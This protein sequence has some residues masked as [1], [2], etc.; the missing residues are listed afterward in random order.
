MEQK[1]HAL[2]R[3]AE[4]LTPEAVTSAMVACLMAVQL[5]NYVF[6]LIGPT[7]AFNVSKSLQAPGSKGMHATALAYTLD[8]PTALDRF[9]ATLPQLAPLLSTLMLGWY[10][11]QVQR[12]ARTFTA[13][14]WRLFVVSAAGT[15]GLLLWIAGT[16]AVA[17]Y[18]SGPAGTA[19]IP[20]NLIPGL[21]PFLLVTLAGASMMVMHSKGEKLDQELEK[22]I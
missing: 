22:V 4:R 3:L 10:Y 15:G 21:T 8:D 19:T 11:W 16:V 9:V 1:P 2:H 13:L 12:K 20:G 5:L 17:L 7:V 14:R 6:A 18:F